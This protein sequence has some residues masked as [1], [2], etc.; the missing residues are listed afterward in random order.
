M[1]V[2]G[3]HMAT[4]WGTHMMEWDSAQ[5]A[6]TWMSPDST[7]LRGRSHTQRIHAVS[8]HSSEAAG[9]HGVEVS[10]ERG[11]RRTGRGRLTGTEV[12]CGEMNVL[13]G[14][15]GRWQRLHSRWLCSVSGTW[16]LQNRVFYAA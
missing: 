15:R 4:M 5:S 14:G 8:S 9:G 2:D 16:T 6:A 11:E 13:G 1:S 10:W 7:A 12:R 3:G